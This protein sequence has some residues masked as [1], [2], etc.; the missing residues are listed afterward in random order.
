MAIRR[1]VAAGAAIAFLV[2]SNVAQASRLEVRD[3]SPVADA[4]ATA[5]NSWIWIASALV[6]GLLLFLLLDDDDEPESP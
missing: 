2:S 4:E 5:G 6:A 3:A 1:I